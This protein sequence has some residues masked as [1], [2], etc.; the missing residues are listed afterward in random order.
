MTFSL[1]D[2]LALTP[3][4]ELRS[5]ALSAEQRFCVMLLRAAMVQGAIVVLDRPFAI[6]PHIRNGRFIME[7]LR[8]LD[9]MIVETHIFDYSWEKERYGGTDV[10]EN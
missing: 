8:K 3:I 9:D 2:R 4:A 10:A 5:P 1:L 6:L 7:T